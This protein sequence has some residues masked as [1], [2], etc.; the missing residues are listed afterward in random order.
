[1]SDHAPP[2]TEPKELF[3]PSEVKQFKS[4]DAEAGAAIGKMLSLFFLYTVLVMAISTL[5]TW[6]WIV[7]N[8]VR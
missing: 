7:H 5:G 6:Y 4:D 8:N 1:M 3:T 2:A